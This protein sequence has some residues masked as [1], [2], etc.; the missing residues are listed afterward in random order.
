[1]KFQ[2][3]KIGQ[4]FEYQGQTYVKS[5]PLVANQIKTGQQKLIPR[6][7]A[8]MVRD[9]ASSPD[10]KTTNV[11]LQSNQVLTAFDT[12]YNCVMDSLH[13]LRPEYESQTFASVQHK[14]NAAR[15]QFLGDLGLHD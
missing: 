3:L 13:K 7:A 10:T 1:M 6:Y 12:F 15:H 2:H 4:Q 14:I 11:T 9:T 8:I 5:G